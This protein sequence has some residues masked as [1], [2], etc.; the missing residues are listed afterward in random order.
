MQ[1]TLTRLRRSLAHIES[2][3]PGPPAVARFG[4]GHAGLDA[5]VGGGLPRAA[6]HE[7]F[8]S[9]AGDGAAAAGFGLAMALC[10]ARAAEPADGRALADG[11]AKRPARPAAPGRTTVWV[12]QAMAGREHGALYPPGLAAFGAD[13]ERLVLVAVRDATGALR[14]AHEALR[15]AALAAVVLE[16]WGPARALDLT[17]SRRLAA[18]AAKSGVGCVLVRSGA[19][20][21]PSAGLS[22][23]GI[24]AGPSI[25]L[26]ANAPGRPAFEI[27]LQRHRA[28]F[29]PGRFSLEWDHDELVFRQPALPRPV[30][31]LPLHRPAAAPRRHAG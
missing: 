15:C 16:L 30:V 2:D 28:G 11:A 19:A 4:F 3:R 31:S 8:A 6:L 1:D 27:E 22:R 10:M 23:W 9:G 25:R 12:Q 24:A 7:V 14:A 13:P 18:A 20:P 17:A 5:A 26:G 21:E 29:P